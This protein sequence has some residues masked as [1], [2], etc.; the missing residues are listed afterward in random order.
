M[1]IPSRKKGESAEDYRSRVI[2]T[3][4]KH[5]KPKNQAVAI[6]YSKTRGSK[7]KGK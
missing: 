4:I 6:A 1:P 5:G 3:E 2:S 7:K